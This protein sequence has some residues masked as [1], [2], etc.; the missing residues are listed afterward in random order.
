M[1]SPVRNVFASVDLEWQIS[2]RSL[3]AMSA[4]GNGRRGE[5]STGNSIDGSG[6]QHCLDS[7]LEWCDAKEKTETVFNC[8]A[9]GLWPTKPR[10]V[11]AS[12]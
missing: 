9:I 8:L 4:S 6:S 7:W 1:K 5:S 2:I 11:A 12:R 3:R 10:Q